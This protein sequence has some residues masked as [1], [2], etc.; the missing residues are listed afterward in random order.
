MIWI[1]IDLPFNKSNN[2]TIIT[3]DP[4]WTDVVTINF[5]LINSA[6]SLGIYWQT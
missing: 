2:D 6:D 4:D 3:K 1:N 5:E